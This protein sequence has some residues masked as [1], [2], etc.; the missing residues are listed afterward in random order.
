MPSQPSLFSSRRIRR[1]A[2]VVCAATSAI[3][4]FAADPPTP[5]P[6]PAPGERPITAQSYSWKNVVIGG[7][8]FVSGL[9]FHP[10]Q[11]DLL[12]ARTDVGGAYR[13]D[14]TA[15]RW[16]PLND[17]LSVDHGQLL[18]I[19]S[20][21]VDPRDP[22]RI[23]LACGQYLQAWGAPAG[24]LWS[25]DQGANWGHAPLPFHLG[26]NADG[27][28]MGERLQVDPHDGQILFLGTNQ[29]GLWR[30][31][32]QGKFWK[33]LE[34]FPASGLTFVL[35]DE[36][37]GTDGKATPTLYAGASDP[38]RP[39]LFQSNDAG[40][41]WKPVPGQPTGLIVHHAAFDSAHT[42]Y[43]AYS[44]GPGPNGI[45]DGAVW[46][47]SPDE[48]KWTNITPVAPNA[49]T[50]DTFG[51][52]GLAVDAQHAGTVV[53]TTLDRWSQGDEIFRTT[54]GG[55]S[56]KAVRATSTWDFS[57]APYA[58]KLKPH[59]LGAIAVDP[60]NSDRAWFVTG[61]GLWAT[62]HLSAVDRGAPTPWI[63]ANDGLEETVIDELVSPPEGVSLL[64]AIGDIGGFRHEDLRVSP[65][66]GA[67]EPPYG[68]NA[69]IAFAERVPAKLART[70]SGPARGALSLD[71]GVTWKDFATTPATAKAKGSGTIALSTDGKRI[72]WL[73]K[74]SA[75]FFS[76]D[77]GATW[78]KSACD[79]TSSSA[80]Q[81]DVVVADR[82]NADKFY[83]YD[84]SK[85][86]VHVSIDGGAHFSAGGQIPPAGGIPRAVP[87]R[88]G[89][90]WIPTPGGL[91]MSTSSGARF[92][93]VHD[94][95]SAFQIGFGAPSQEGGP[96]TLF[97]LG[98]VRNIPALFRSNDLGAS[99]IVISDAG[100]KFGYLKT[101]SGDPRVP[102][103]VY[104]GT[105][106]RGIIV[107]DPQ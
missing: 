10:K 96:P 64:S 57:F 14:A 44:N 12:F 79:F 42:L 7:G 89:V 66:A 11:R 16:I 103:R 63:F 41:S 48:S 17:N 26:G 1:V 38:K 75:P 51:Y 35:F 32:S 78:S 84:S 93:R 19:V 6:A 52:A 73:P 43:L 68:S 50:K 91:F 72:V 59:W 104:L 25:P 98:R 82:V 34:K 105:G 2:L 71:G 74:G 67:H 58:G 28:S 55:A 18:G 13:W 88:E 54:D 99:W 3:G 70:H 21:A 107:G 40:L 15:Q 65:R 33:R 30:S 101:I 97:M 62:Q 4:L 102:G 80:Y 86:V 95:A 92:A 22:Q 24:I 60:F 77:D 83:L 23:Y 29:D 61:Y 47:F 94:V 85:G 76:S 9:V 106:G 69:S 45:T 5:A 53:V 56:W 20:F 46:K 90:L 87:G 81:T 49:A 27:R 8:G 100:H 36:R 31:E 37:S 39:A